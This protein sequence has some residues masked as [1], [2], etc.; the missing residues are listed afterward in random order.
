MRS[1]SA[2]TFGPVAGGEPVAEPISEGRATQP[3]TRTARMEAD[4]QPNHDMLAL[5]LSVDAA[6]LHQ[7][8]AEAVALLAE[9]EEHCRGVSER[10]SA[11]AR[12]AL[13]LHH[14]LKH[15]SPMQRC[16]KR[17]KAT[18]SP[19]RLEGIMWHLLG[20]GSPPPFSCARRNRRDQAITTG[21]I[22]IQVSCGGGVAISHAMEPARRTRATTALD[23]RSTQS[24]GM[25][26]LARSWA[27]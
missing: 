22:P 20:G 16:H 15:Y 11:D 1:C 17:C 18:G 12:I 2:S 23:A 6:R 25:F 9:A 27:P 14:C 3:R 4:R 10:A 13:P 19:L 8:D 7:A 26:D 5:H 24:R 21:N